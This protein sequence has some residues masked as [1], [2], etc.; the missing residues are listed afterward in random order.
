MMP[1]QNG[2]HFSDILKTIFWNEIA[3]TLIEMSLQLVPKGPIDTK[4]TLVQAMARD[5]FD[6]KLE[7]EPMQLH[8][9]PDQHKLD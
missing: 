4:L 7:H 3:W 8:Y 5:L 6:V 1:K 9:Q 2:C